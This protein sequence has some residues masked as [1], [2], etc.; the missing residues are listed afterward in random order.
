MPVNLELKYEYLFTWGGRLKII[1]IVS[2]H[3]I[4]TYAACE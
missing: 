3:C 1:E 2:P 4:C